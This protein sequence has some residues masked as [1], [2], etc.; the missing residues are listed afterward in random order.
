MLVDQAI[1]CISIKCLKTVH[2]SVDTV[3]HYYVD[4]RMLR[5]LSYRMFMF[6]RM[7]CNINIIL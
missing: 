7:T 5:I 6:V 2:V 1:A 4:D 3:W